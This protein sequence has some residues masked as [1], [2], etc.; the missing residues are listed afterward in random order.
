[1]KKL[2]FLLLALALVLV[3][4]SDSPTAPRI[5]AGWTASCYD[6]VCSFTNQSTGGN[7]AV[8]N[9]GD[10][11]P[12]IADWNVTHRYPAC[13]AFFVTMTVCPNKDSSQDKC[14]VSSGLVRSCP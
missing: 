9:V 13:D 14:D 6:M 3:A 10:G 5:T 7:Y 11:S 8:W 1:M 12:Q 2:I 4:C